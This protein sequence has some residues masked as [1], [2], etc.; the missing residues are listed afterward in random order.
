MWLMILSQN[1]ESHLFLKFIQWKIPGRQCKVLKVNST[2]KSGYCK[3]TDRSSWTGAPTGRRLPGV[4]QIFS[5]LLTF[6]LLI[7]IFLTP[8]TFIVYYL[9][10][11]SFEVEALD[12]REKQKQKLEGGPACGT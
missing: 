4:T 2:L 10:K 8:V 11:I 5:S 12:S 7:L 1:S 3:P 6:P 9:V